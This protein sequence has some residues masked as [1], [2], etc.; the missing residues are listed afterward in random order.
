MTMPA[1]L[2]RGLWTCRGPKR[3]GQGILASSPSHGKDAVGLGR[4]QGPYIWQTHV[5]IM[6]W[7]SGRVM[8]LHVSRGL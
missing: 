5:Q 2:R 6:A 3:E 4:G 7:G 8:S 1:S